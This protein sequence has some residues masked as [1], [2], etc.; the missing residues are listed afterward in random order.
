[1]H[2]L[3]DPFLSIVLVIAIGAVGGAMTQW[4]LR[5]SRGAEA[6]VRRSGL[7]TCILVGIAGAFLGFHA[8]MLSGLGTAQPIVPFLVTVVVAGG[9][10]WGWHAAGI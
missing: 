7:L 6:L 3:R 5:R 1:M 8:A 10:L 9:V 2:R 4:I